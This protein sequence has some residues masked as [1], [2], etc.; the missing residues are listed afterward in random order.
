ML[1]VKMDF[2]TVCDWLEPITLTLPDSTE[3]EVTKALRRAISQRE[4]GSQ[5]PEDTEGQTLVYDTRWHLPVSQVPTAP[6]I[7]SHISDGIT[8]WEVVWVDWQTGVNR[9]LCSSRQI[10]TLDELT[11]RFTLQIGAYIKAEEGD[12]AINWSSEITNLLGSMSLRAERIDFRHDKQVA[13]KEYV[14]FLM[15]DEP[16]EGPLRLVDSDGVVYNVTSGS[17]RKQIGAIQRFE[18]EREEFGR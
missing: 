15:N 8:I 14:S 2:E 9:W 7:G 13:V 11:N 17:G 4:G 1:D 3:I 18:C 10:V 16:M 12:A 6:L 5:T